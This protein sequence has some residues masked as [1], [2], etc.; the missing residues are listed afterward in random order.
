MKR[1]AEVLA[2]VLTDTPD[3]QPVSPWDLGAAEE[4]LRRMA[5]RGVPVR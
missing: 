2:R 5:E 4:I 3:D 1:A